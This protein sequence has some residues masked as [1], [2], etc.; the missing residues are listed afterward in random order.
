MQLRT[1]MGAIKNELA[2]F[3]IDGVVVRNDFVEA[4]KQEYNLVIQRITAL[5]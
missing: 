4:L 5:A 2:K 1:S 3:V